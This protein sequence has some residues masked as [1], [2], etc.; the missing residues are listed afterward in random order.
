MLYEY[1]DGQIA[2][3][4]PANEP[5][6]TQTVS[7]E[8]KLLF[9]APSLGEDFLPTGL[10][11]Y[12]S[13][14]SAYYPTHLRSGRMFGKFPLPTRHLTENL[15]EHLAQSEPIGWEADWEELVAVHGRE[16]LARVVREAWSSATAL[17]GV[18]NAENTLRHLF[19]NWSSFLR[20]NLDAEYYL[21][22][23]QTLDLLAMMR[24][25]EQQAEKSEEAPGS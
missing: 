5:K 22:L 3:H 11:Y 7:V 9:A 14:G 17:I 2:I 8:G 4:T 16:L 18:E 23:V 6:T 1:R 13:R 15:L 21:R 19:S 20:A 24:L 25:A 10:G 12:L